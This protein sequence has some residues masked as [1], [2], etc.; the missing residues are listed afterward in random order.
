MKLIVKA[1]CNF[2]ATGFLPRLLIAV[3]VGIQS[4]LLPIGAQA[5]NR[6]VAAIRDTEIE[7]L[8]RDYA[9]P[10]FKAAY[11]NHNAVGI[12]IINDRSF[13]AFV[14]NG[15]RL[16]IN[17][18]ALMT[19]ATP[20]EI[21]GVIAHE[22][23]HIAGGHLARQR[24]ALEKAQTASII[25]MLLGAGAIA[26]GSG[27]AGSAVIS[28]G[29]NAVTRMFLSYKRAEESAADRAAVKYLTASGQSARGM[30]KTFER[31]ADQQLFSSRNV[32]PYFLSH[33]MARERIS[34]LQHSA[35]Q[36]PYFDRTDPP[37]LQLRHDLMRAKLSG[38]LEHRDTVIQRYPRSDNSLPARYARAISLYLH[39]DVRKGVKA[40]DQLLKDMP[41]NPY[42]WELKGQALLESGRPG[43]AI[44]PLKRAVSLAPNAG[45]IRLML[46]K[47]LLATEQ[48]QNLNTAIS[49]LNRAL[50]REPEASDGLRQL[51]IAY[52]RKGDIAR[53][54]LATARAYFAEGDLNQAKQH[55]ARVQKR[56][57][58]GT[59]LWLQADDILTFRAPP[60]N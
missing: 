2:P 36:S 59:P 52:G 34:S 20:N 44:A 60:G 31:F 49:E 28:G 10:I 40:V 48:P 19:S 21:I 57:Q 1:L 45:L 4:A 5:Q 56:T 47:A 22:T 18:G 53:A 33:P 7:T 14:A 3:A 29:Q 13:N 42:F 51:A 32:D 15:R 24:E 6:G 43:E 41:N 27:S 50:S 39:V 9:V 26:S 11:V 38:F 58:R 16:F 37:A 17:A 35:E 12:Y 55:A 46:G 8:V 30:L 54:E 25:A 23:G